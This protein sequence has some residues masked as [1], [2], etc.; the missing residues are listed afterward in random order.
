MKP[1]SVLMSPRVLS[2]L[3]LLS[4]LW[5]AAPARAQGDSQASADRPV[6]SSG[7][8]FNARLGGGVP[9]GYIH[10]GDG[11]TALAMNDIV[12]AMIPVELN[13]G[14]FLGS[15]VYVGAY[16]QYGRLLLAEDC[17]QAAS[18]SATNLRFGANASLHLPVSDSGRW[19]PWVGG[20]IGYELFKPGEGTLNGVDFHVQ[21]GADYH[22]SGPVWVGP[23]AEFTLGKYS[24]VNDPGSH[25]WLIGGVRILMRH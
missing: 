10:N 6:Q 18:C 15:S 22:A 5:V 20:G 12:S 21:V 24:D 8:S 1:R 19:S 25:K 11:E 13:G 17:P 2:A 9:L 7:F 16:F 4:L 23:F 14:V 3:L